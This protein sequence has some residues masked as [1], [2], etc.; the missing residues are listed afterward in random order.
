M[1]KPLSVLAILLTT[2]FVLVAC[3]DDD[4]ETTTNGATSATGASGAALSESEY[5]AQANEICKSGERE[6]NQAVKETFGSASATGSQAGSQAEVKEFV[7][8]TVVPNI[9]SQIDDIRALTPPEDQADEFEGLLDNAQA[10]LDELEADPSL[11]TH[12]DPFA[13]VNREA[14]ELG[15]DGCS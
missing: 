5:R 10:A 1:K 11:F 2:I 13:D 9:Q 14:A 6:I 15:L 3:G 8:E 7:N 12:A 4:D